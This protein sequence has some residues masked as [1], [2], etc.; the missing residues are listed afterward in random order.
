MSSP[1]NDRKLGHREPGSQTST[2]VKIL[3]L[4]YLP[5][6]KLE[7]YSQ[8]EKSMSVAL[9]CLSLVWGRWEVFYHD[10]SSLY[11]SM[12]FKNKVGCLEKRRIIAL[13][14]AQALS[15]G[16]YLWVI[17]GSWTARRKKLKRALVC[18]TMLLASGWEES[19][20]KHKALRHFQWKGEPFVLPAG[21]QRAVSTWWDHQLEGWD[22]N[23][24]LLGQWM[25]F[26][27]LGV[28]YQADSWQQV[29]V[30]LVWNVS[31]ILT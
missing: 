21:W 7:V 22:V 30:S 3:P 19:K 27:S 4:N 6:I 5:N 28:L 18:S 23:G 17:K 20:T 2:Y 26:C 14:S 9:S 24:Q 16:K 1:H 11:G 12:W 10:S 13:P 29:S 25:L 31:Q 15:S 8:A